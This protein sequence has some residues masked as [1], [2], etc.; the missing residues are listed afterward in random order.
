MTRTAVRHIISAVIAVAVVTA[1]ADNPIAAQPLD[2]WF[3]GQLVGETAEKT[4]KNR[5][6]FTTQTP[7][8]QTTTHYQF[9]WFQ[10]YGGGK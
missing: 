9:R 5:K 3:T 7:S 4:S 6:G 1:F 10:D 8:R 2:Q